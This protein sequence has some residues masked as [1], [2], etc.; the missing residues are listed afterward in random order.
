[1]SNGPASA[2]NV[3]GL[4]VRQLGN[5]HDAA[6]EML[7]LAAPAPGEVMIAPDACALNF[8]DLLLIEEKYQYK[9]PLPFF[10]GR[11]V[12]GKIVAVGSGVSAFAVGDRVSAQLRHG[13]FAELALAPVER[14]FRVPESV[15]ASKAAAAGTIFA[16]A[17]VALTMRAQVRA[18]ERVL[19]TGAAGGVGIAT[20]QYAKHLGAEVV[21]LVSSEAKANAVRKVGA[22]QVVHLDQLPEPSALRDT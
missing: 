11:D 1:M 20:I 12:A 19:V 17:A 7:P 2:R 4:V 16:T 9:P 21:A 10:V 8:Q 13:A 14:C 3:R 6:I 15:D 22:D 18:G 5:W